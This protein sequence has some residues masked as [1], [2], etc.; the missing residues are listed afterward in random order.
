MTNP[1]HIV[2]YGTNGDQKFFSTNCDKCYDCVAI[3]ANMIAFSPNALSIFINKKA[4][5]KGFFIDPITHAFQHSQSFITDESGRKIKKS[6]SNLIKAYTVGN[7][8]QELI[9]TD[10][11]KNSLGTNRS[12]VPSDLDTDFVQSFA[13]NVLEYQINLVS[14]KGSEM[15]E[16][17]NFAAQSDPTL[18]DLTL[19]QKPIFLVAPYFYLDGLENND[20]WLEKNIE[21]LKVSSDLKQSNKLFAQIVISRKLIERATIN[22]YEKSELK[23]KII[24]KYKEALVDGFLLWIDEFSEHDEI[25]PTLETYNELLKDLKSTGKKVIA[26]YGGYYSVILSSKDVGLLDGIAHGLEYGEKRGVIPVGGGLP[27]AKF[28]FYPL[29]KRINYSD[30]VRSLISLRIKTKEDYFEKICKCEMCKE[31]VKSD[32]VLEEF[33]AYGESEPS[34]FKRGDTIV[35]MSFSTSKAKAFSLTHYLLS[36]S[37]EFEEA[38]KDIKVIIAE[39]DEAL[40]LYKDYFDDQSTSHLQEWSKAITSL[41]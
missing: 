27:V 16:Y 31:L 26:L 17:I 36:K 29:H 23:T 9:T 40:A 34:T 28:Y 7:K 41:L 13:K 37:K 25:A 11:E 33:M 18:S 30:M 38:N 4:V 35:T 15:S 19:N 20:K 8:L 32:K 2:R 10:G 21:L 1:L 22:T 3:N 12:L 6:I 14:K 24:A 5:G 39:L